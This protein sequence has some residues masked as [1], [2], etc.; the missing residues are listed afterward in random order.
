MTWL[1]NARRR[2]H[3][4]YRVL[5]LVCSVQEARKENTLSEVISAIFL[6]PS[7]PANRSRTNR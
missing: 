2:E 7:L 1:K 4:E 3:Q 5:R 6:F